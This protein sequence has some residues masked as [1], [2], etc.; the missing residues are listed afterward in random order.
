MAKDDPILTTM[1]FTPKYETVQKYD[2]LLLDTLTNQA[3][4]ESEAHKTYH[5]FAARKSTVISGS[6]SLGIVPQ[7]NVD[8][9]YLLW[10][11]FVYQ[12]E[13]KDA[14]KSNEM[15]YPMYTKVIIHYFMIKDPSIP[16]RN[17]VNW[18]YVRDDQM[19]TTIKLLPQEPHH[20]RLSTSATATDTRL[21]TFAQGK[22]PAKASKAK[23]E[24]TGIIPG[25]PDVPTEESDE[26]ISW[27]S[28]DEDDD[29]DDVDEGSDD[30]HDDD[31]HDDDNHDDDDQDEGDDDDDQDEGNDEEGDNA[32][33]E[34]LDK[35]EINEDEE[36]NEL[37][38]DVNINLEGRDTKMKDAS[39]ANV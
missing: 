3:M 15:Y 32:E 36:V 31:D 16:R 25:F 8:F 2:A 12:V 1:R 10:E 34:E 7:E 13:H 11:D 30:Q 17:K 6:D 29:D 20:L 35:K 33:G 22:Q 4:K 9:S 19:F 27:K 21:S 28:S 26:E 38:R 37:Y 39:L 14:K 23:N 24:G 18:H 5:D